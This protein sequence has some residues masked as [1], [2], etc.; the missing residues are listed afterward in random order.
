ML[1][2]GM[3]KAVAE[4][5]KTNN[6]GAVDLVK[7]DIVSLYEEDFWKL[8]NTGRAAA[9]CDAIPAQLSKN[10]SRYQISAAIPGER[11][12][13]VTGIVKMMNDFRS[14]NVAYHS[15]EP[16]VGLALTMDNER[17]KIYAS[18]TGIFVTLAFKDKDFSGNI[19]YEKL[20]ND[21]LRLIGVMSMR[22]S[23]R[24]CCGLRVNSCFI[25]RYHL[26][27]GRNTMRWIF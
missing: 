17:F 24:R 27:T 14:A 20:L 11:A 6:L 10:A 3:P 8:D 15:N 22:M 1:V 19:I 23:L 21:K 2:G 7:R 25:I 13:R 9:L 4:Y 5:I 26:Q 16:N 12:E 18:D